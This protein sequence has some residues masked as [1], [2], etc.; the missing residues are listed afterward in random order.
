MKS[1]RENLI[2]T[3]RRIFRENVILPRN[4][5][6]FEKLRFFRENFDFDNFNLFEQITIY[7]NIARLLTYIPIS[8]FFRKSRTT[9]TT[10]RQI[11][12][13]SQTISAHTKFPTQPKQRRASSTTIRSRLRASFKWWPLLRTDQL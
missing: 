2:L 6:F 9:T 1:F 10:T 11:T 13:A 8:N 3:S 7:S 12:R 5:D 4:F